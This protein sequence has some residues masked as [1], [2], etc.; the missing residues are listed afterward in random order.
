MGV[1]STINNAAGRGRL[2]VLLT[3]DVTGV[4]QLELV[5][6][7]DGVLASD[8]RRLVGRGVCKFR[9]AGDEVAVGLEVSC[10]Q[11]DF[12]KR[13]TNSTCGYLIVLFTTIVLILELVQPEVPV[14]VSAL[15]DEA[16]I[17]VNHSIVVAV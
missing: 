1:T 17:V 11:G 2:V 6:F 16:F 3:E 4:E 8:D 13:F 9:G 15:C 10:C 7:G 14:G 12:D 5:V